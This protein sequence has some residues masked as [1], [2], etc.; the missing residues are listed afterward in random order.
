MTLPAWINTQTG[1]TNDNNVDAAVNV[2]DG[3]VILIPIYDCTG[4]NIGQQISATTACPNP[5]TGNGSG[6]YYHIVALAPFLL[7]HAFINGNPKV[8]GNIRVCDGY[9]N[10]PGLP[11]TQGNGATGCL[12]GWFVDTLI[13][14]VPIGLGGVARSVRL[15]SEFNSS[16]RWQRPSLVVVCGRPVAT[17]TEGFP[18]GSLQP[19][20]ASPPLGHMG[21][22]AHRRVGVRRWLSGFA[23]DQS[24][25]GYRRPGTST[26]RMVSPP[27]C[28]G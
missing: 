9:P 2:Y 6:L 7:D 19:Q 20:S 27:T 25:S 23:T 5:W 10:S 11:S 17:P 1:N 28:H 3:Q 14:D 21:T 24:T 26:R 4:Q 18:F 13:T 16:S 8:S 22:G 12:K 15:P